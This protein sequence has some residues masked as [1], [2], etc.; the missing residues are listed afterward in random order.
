[1]LY[2]FIL[3]GYRAQTAFSVKCVVNIHILLLLQIITV[4]LDLGVGDYFNMR[5]YI[6]HIDV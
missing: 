4:N 2:Y 5:L 1:M 3:G 6:V